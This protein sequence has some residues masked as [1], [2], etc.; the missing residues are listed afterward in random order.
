MSSEKRKFTRIPLHFPVTLTLDD[1]SVHEVEEFINIS[2]GGSL[3]PKTPELSNSSTCKIV[4]KLGDDPDSDLKIEASGDIV[5]FG[6]DNL[7]VKFTHIDP[8]SLFHLHNIIRYNA[9]DPDT[10]D[11]EIHNHPGLF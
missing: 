4:I 10:V 2:V 8:D 11:D 5:R 7:A 9:E 3:L 6:E 1:G